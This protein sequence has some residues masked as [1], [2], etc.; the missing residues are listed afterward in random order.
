[1]LKCT[2]D[3]PV[4]SFSQDAYVH[5]VDRLGFGIIG[6]RKGSEFWKEFRFAFN[7]EMKDAEGLLGQI[8]EMEKEVLESRGT[9]SKDIVNDG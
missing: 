3:V 1:M 5:D 2:T 6:N 9:A 4:T 8:A 7:N